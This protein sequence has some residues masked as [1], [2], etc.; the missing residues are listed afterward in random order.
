M[1]I[2]QECV[3]A[4]RKHKNLKLAALDVGIPWQSTYVH[5]RN[6]GEPV[7]GDKVRYGSDKDR[8]AAK[9]EALFKSFVP[10]AVD[11]NDG[12]YQSKID[13]IVHGYSVDVKSSTLRLSN[14]ACKLRRWAFSMKKQ[15]MLADFFVC[16]CFDIDGDELLK[17]ML[18]P[19][20]IVRKYA[21]ISLSEMGSKWDD[22]II[23]ADELDTFFN[24]LPPNT[25]G[26]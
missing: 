22:Y 7:T 25:A 6:A 21:T 2:Q 13:F 15:E 12:K 26:A 14:K 17:L 5:L 16:L 19:G 9:A 1:S 18:V 11:Q 8:L 24:S 3:T 4:Y 20:E 10:S 23:A